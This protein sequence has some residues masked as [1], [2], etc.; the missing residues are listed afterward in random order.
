MLIVSA[1]CLV[2]SC[3]SGLLTI[4]C[5]FFGKDRATNPHVLY[6]FAQSLSKY[7]GVAAVTG[8]FF[9]VEDATKSQKDEELEPVL[10]EPLWQWYYGLQDHCRIQT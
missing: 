1:V 7:L 6:P 4:T 5:V 10:S 8:A 9:A 3:V 2:T